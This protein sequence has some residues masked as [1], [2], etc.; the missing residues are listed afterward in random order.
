MKIR[1]HL[2]NRMGVGSELPHVDTVVVKV[3][4][5]MWLKALFFGLDLCV[6]SLMFPKLNPEEHDEPEG[7]VEPDG[8]DEPEERMES[9]EH[10]KPEVH[11]ELDEPEECKV[12]EELVSDDMS[13]DDMSNEVPEIEVV[14]EQVQHESLKSEDIKDL[15]TSVSQK[16][17]RSRKERTKKKQDKTSVMDD[18]AVFGVQMDDNTI[19]FQD[20]RTETITSSPVRK[21]DNNSDNTQFKLDE[22]IKDKTTSTQS[23]SVVMQAQTPVSDKVEIDFTNPPHSPRWKPRNLPPRP[24]RKSRQESV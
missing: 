14:P 2:D 1:L 10:N 18:V 23:M 7:H 13:N 20:G 3:S 21:V 19:V 9:D 4:F 12:S 24:V 11:V 22:D 17:S 8:Y 6:T 5:L 16:S 15:A